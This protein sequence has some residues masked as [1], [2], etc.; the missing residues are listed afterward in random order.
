MNARFLVALF[1][2]CLFVTPVTHADT[3]PDLLTRLESAA[4][5]D[6]AWE[7]YRARA[8][9][10]DVSGLPPRPSATTTMLDRVVW[11]EAFFRTL[12]DAG[13]IFLKRFPGDPRR[14]D[15]T[16]DFYLFGFINDHSHTP[17]QRAA[18]ERVTPAA[19]RAVRRAEVDRMVAALRASPDSPAKI[20]LML[21]LYHEDS[22]L[23][24]YFRKLPEELAAGRAPDASPLLKMADEIAS[25]Y[26][27][28]EEWEGGLVFRFE[29][30][31]RG[32][33]MSDERIITAMEPLVGSQRKG[34]RE[35][36]SLYVAN[37][38]LVGKTPE[39]AFT[40]LDG[41]AVDLKQMRGKVVLIDCWATWCGPCKAE[42][43]NLK[44][45]YAAYHDKGLEMIGLTAERVPLKQE[46]TPEEKA[47]KI[48]A[49]RK[50]LADFVVQEQMPWPQHFSELGFRNPFYA[51]F[52]VTAIPLAVLIDRDGKVITTDTQ[53][54]KLEP[55]VRRALGL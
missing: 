29:Q 40:A 33:R 50:A 18:I 7:V 16:R 38:R 41:R 34:I 30:A 23:T 20:R 25:K 9:F 35:I 26:P 28:A 32:A 17:E 14:W 47:K 3:G 42:L 13:H 55:A 52:G 22:P 45:V 19:E 2:L 5:A 51:Q 39:V 31:L 48:E 36:A 4:T 8:S 21:D 46:D 54:E 15:V 24:R 43:P 12:W 10:K 27:D 11:Q 49:A 6:A 44:R 1:C 37:R 53:G